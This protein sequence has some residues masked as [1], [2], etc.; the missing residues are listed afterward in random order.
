MLQPSLSTSPTVDG[1]TQDIPLQLPSSE[2]TRGEIQCWF[3]EP[4][5]KPAWTQLWHRQDCTESC[6][7]AL[8]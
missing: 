3:G 5:S 4:G 7:P 8:K 2:Q 1:P 6:S